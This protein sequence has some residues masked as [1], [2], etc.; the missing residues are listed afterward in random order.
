MSERLLL[1]DD[2][3]DIRRFLGLFLSDLG[4]EVH[5]AENGEKALGAAGQGRPKWTPPLRPFHSSP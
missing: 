5:A 2:E 4:Y 1:V 3:E